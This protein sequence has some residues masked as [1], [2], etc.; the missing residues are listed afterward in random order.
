M[1]SKWV[2]EGGKRKERG[3]VGVGFKE[4]REEKIVLFQKK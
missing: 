4:N 3:R 1:G 2:L